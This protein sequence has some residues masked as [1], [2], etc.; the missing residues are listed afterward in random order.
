MKVLIRTI[1]GQPYFRRVFRGY[2]ASFG[3][4]S[5]PVLWKKTSNGPTVDIS[6]LYGEY[7]IIDIPTTCKT[8]EDFYSLFPEYLL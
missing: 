4:L 8:N 7:E 3:T 2:E 1:N 5:I 6:D